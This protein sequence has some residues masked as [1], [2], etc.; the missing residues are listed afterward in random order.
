MKSQALLA[1]GLIFVTLYLTMIA[2][3]VHHEETKKRANFTLCPLCN[4]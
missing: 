4:K 2:I 1:T 3:L